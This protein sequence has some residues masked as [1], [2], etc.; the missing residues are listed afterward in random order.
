MVLLLACKAMV[1]WNEEFTH[2][3]ARVSEEEEVKRQLFRQVHHPNILQGARVA[4]TQLNKKMI[5]IRSRWPVCARISSL[6][7]GSHATA[8]NVIA[9]T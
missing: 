4:S 8:P 9:T 2:Q 5:F 1:P 6:L 3:Y 7:D